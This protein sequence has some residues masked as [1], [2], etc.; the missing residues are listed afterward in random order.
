MER[1]SEIVEI[2]RKLHIRILDEVEDGNKSGSFFEYLPILATMGDFTTTVFPSIFCHSSF[3]FLGSPGAAQLFFV[4]AVT[5]VVSFLLN[6]LEV[7][8]FSC[9]ENLLSTLRG[10]VLCINV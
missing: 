2:F 9:L 6:G 4:F 10:N 7:N 1:T 8:T 3:H 5:N